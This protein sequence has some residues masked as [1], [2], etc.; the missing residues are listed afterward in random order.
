MRFVFFGLSIASSWG[1][2]HATT[3]RGLVRELA[4]RGHQVTFFEKRTPWYDANCD[5]PEADYCAIRRYQSWPPEGASSA[6]AGADVIT[7]GSYTG[8]GIALADWLPA[9]ARG[10]L[11]YYDIDT[12]VT[13]ERLRAAGRADYLRADQLARFDAV[14]SFAG[15]PSLD[16]LRRFGARRAEPFYCAVD[17]DL[18]RPA[19]PDP[20][21]ACDL[22]YMGTYG[23]E[24]Q[25][26]VEELLFAPARLLPRRRFLV[27]GAQYP[28]DLDWPP[29]A[30]N[31]SHVNPPD[32]PAFFA[33]SAWQ[34]KVLR[35]P[36]RRLGWAPSVTLFEIA[37]CG[38]SIISDR[39]P[40]FE[41]FFAPG[42]EA[43]LADT[44]DDVVSA[45]DVPESR[46][47]RIAEA[48]RRR[49]LAS[50]T[51][52]QRVDQLEALLSDLGAA[53]A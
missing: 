42:E 3:Y 11:L 18:Y 35:I 38:A 45:F 22:G 4:A 25:D 15:G 43:L 51:Y 12:P 13:L 17:A 33:A 46:R 49:V 39:W 8:D 9:H 20:R 27:G 21:F 16:E 5:L 28:P 34:L 7:L 24:R 1:N 29:N 30:A 36:M 41:D 6:V 44:R 48:G 2:G 32:H 10:V 14:L 40:G 26:M 19:A 52:T 47:R 53:A 50:H 31:I 37:A 23:S